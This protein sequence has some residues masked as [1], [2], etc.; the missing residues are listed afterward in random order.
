MA[1]VFA[2][3]VS[4]TYFGLQQTNEANLSS[5]TGMIMGH[6]TAIAVDG[7]GNIYA[8]RQS[9]NAIVEGGMEMIA[10]Q[11]FEGING[12]ATYRGNI[13]SL[14]AN[15]V[16]AIGIGVN[17]TAVTSQDYYI[18][19]V[20]NNPGSGAGC[21]NRTVALGNFL[22]WTA[23]TVNVT[24]AYSINN[25]A[26]IGINGTATFGPSV[27]CGAPTT[28]NEAGAFDNDTTAQMFARNTYNSVTL[29]SADSLIIN[30]N[31]QFNDS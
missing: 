21:Q 14:G 4:G 31:F 1:A 19:A 15:P 11:V 10:S 5:S 30:W 20:D 26:L 28:Y 18:S 29:G 3:G 6:V 22:G 17:A 7:E 27:L 24:R 8:Y 23:G 2:V 13:G 9:D 16:D 12:T 25:I